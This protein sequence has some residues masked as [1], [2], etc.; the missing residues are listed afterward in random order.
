[1]SFDKTVT[2][3]ERKYFSEKLLSVDDISPTKW[4][5]FCLISNKV[6]FSNRMIDFVKC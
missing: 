4:M 1:M 2:M 3:H 6:C 5:H